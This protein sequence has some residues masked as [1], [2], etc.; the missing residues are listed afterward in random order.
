MPRSSGQWQSIRQKLKSK[1]V[2]K[3]ASSKAASQKAGG[4]PLIMHIRS[5]LLWVPIQG[6][7]QSVR[8]ETSAS[9]AAVT[10]L[11][12]LLSGRPIPHIKVSH[13]SQPM[14]LHNIHSSSVHTG[15]ARRYLVSKRSLI[16]L[17]LCQTVGGLSELVVMHY[18]K[19]P[20]EAASAVKFQPHSHFE[21]AQP[22]ICQ[23]QS[24]LPQ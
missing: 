10:I 13:T 8:M 19:V 23:I 5:E 17:K 18:K 1:G 24:F 22:H 9:E 16:R 3:H 20:A 21:Y 11:T 14:C 15:S 12:I 7:E 4:K 2:F 6:L